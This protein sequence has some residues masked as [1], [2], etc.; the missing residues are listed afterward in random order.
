M[1]AQ[2][3]VAEHAALPLSAQAQHVQLH[4]GGP[5]QVIRQLEH[6]HL[7]PHGVDLVLGSF[8]LLLLQLP[9]LVL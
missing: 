1:Q 5:Q 9:S 4:T 3:A 2:A 6:D 7:V 8:R